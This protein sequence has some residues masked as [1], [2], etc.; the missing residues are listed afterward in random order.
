MNKINSL[1]SRKKSPILEEN[2]P[3]KWSRKASSN[4]KP[5]FVKK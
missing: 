1:K 2:A 4:R 3:E 5:K